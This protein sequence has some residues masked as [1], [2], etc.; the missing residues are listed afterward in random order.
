MIVK[1]AEKVDLS[2]LGNCLYVEDKSAFADCYW[3]VDNSTI[4]DY[5]ERADY[6]RYHP[7]GLYGIIADCVG[8]DDQNVG[9][10]V[11]GGSSGQ[12]L[13]ELVAAGIIGRGLFTHFRQHDGSRS[14]DSSLTCINGDLRDEKTWLDMFNWKRAFAPGGFAI[15]MHRPVGGVQN[16]PPRVY[17]GAVHLLLDMT[18]PGGLLFTQIPRRLYGQ[19]EHAQGTVKDYRVTKELSAVCQG[20][21]QRLGHDAVLLSRRSANQH[22]DYSD[23][24]ALIL[25]KVPG[26]P[27][28]KT[29]LAR[30][31]QRTD[32]LA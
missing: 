17:Q 5:G 19:E 16:L 28:W 22:F 32:Q 10:D 9:L 13:R 11:A 8:Q 29:Q 30:A 24:F 26:A 27:G 4:Q 20:L 25:N 7:L 6:S 3:D 18:R 1:M 15:T 23:Q 2:F 21:R 14:I 12:A 31:R